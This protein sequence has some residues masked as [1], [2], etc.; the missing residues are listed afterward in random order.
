[1]SKCGHTFIAWVSDDRVRVHTDLAEK[2]RKRVETLTRGYRVDESGAI[3]TEQKRLDAQRKA[4]C[5]SRRA[6]K[7]HKDL[8]PDGVIPTTAL[9]MTEAE[10]TKTRKKAKHMLRGSRGKLGL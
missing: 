5:E 8:A 10:R 3:R 7:R 9:T 4:R 1:M 6:W 2:L